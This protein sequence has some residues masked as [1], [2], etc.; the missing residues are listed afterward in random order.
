MILFEL[1][2]KTGTFAL[3]YSTSTLQIQKMNQAKSMRELIWLGFLFI[4]MS[5]Y[6]RLNILF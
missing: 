3:N 6:S 5:N 2:E 1:N 4:A